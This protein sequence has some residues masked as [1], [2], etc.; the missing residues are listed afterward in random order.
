MRLRACRSIIVVVS[1]GAFFSS[2]LALMMALDLLVTLAVFHVSVASAE[3]SWQ[4][5][6][7]FLGSI[8]TN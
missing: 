5:G 4:G 7:D 3:D 6:P 1:G 2:V 8:S